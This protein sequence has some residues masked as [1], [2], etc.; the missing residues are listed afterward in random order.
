MGL[1]VVKTESPGSNGHLH[2]HHTHQGQ[3]IPN[4][5]GGSPTKGQGQTGSLQLL[6]YQGGF[7]GLGPEHEEVVGMDQNRNVGSGQSGATENGTDGLLKSGDH[8]QACGGGSRE[9][10]G[11][12]HFMHQSSEN[13][14][15][16][17]AMALRNGN[18]TSGSNSS[19]QQQLQ[20]L[21]QGAHLVQGLYNTHHGLSG[22][23]ANG[24]GGT[25]MEI[26]LDHFDISF[27]NQFSDLINDFISVDSG[28]ATA[29]AA[30]TLYT[31]QLVAPP[32]SEGTATSG[33]NQQQGQEDTT[34]RAAGYSPSELCLQS[35]CS[36]QALGGGAGGGS[37]E[38]GSLAYMHVA[39]VVSAAVAQGTLGMLQSTGRLFMVTDY[40]PEWS[41]PEVC[42]FELN[43][44][45]CTCCTS[46]PP[47]QLYSKMT[48]DNM[49]LLLLL[50]IIIIVVI[51]IIYTVVLI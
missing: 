51:V 1:Q 24:G 37:G 7:P 29:G 18:T 8:L 6:Q 10:G 32:G 21:L 35:C 25:G 13:G 45:H 41:Y 23:G 43:A 26:S 27:G 39:E 11:A 44:V 30:G 48:L 31:H 17:E 40:S 46:F 5:N 38:T 22:A 9:S 49:L 28:V 4:C 36:P 12:N 20:P 14:A 42:L 33:G 16:A 15:G 3:H 47:L 2:H 19:S 50:T 34:N